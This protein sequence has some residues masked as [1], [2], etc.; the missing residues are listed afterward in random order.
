VVIARHAE[1]HTARHHLVEEAP[2]D[3]GV[4]DVGHVELVE[5]H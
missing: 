5:A 3:H 1:H 2:E 4:G